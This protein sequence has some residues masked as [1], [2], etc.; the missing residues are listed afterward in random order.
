MSVA[1]SQ[2][3]SGYNTQNDTVAQRITEANIRH[4]RKDSNAGSSILTTNTPRVPHIK[5]LNV[6]S[7]FGGPSTNTEQ[8]IVRDDKLN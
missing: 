8:S 6:I 5:G 3:Q 1:F 2:M 7:Q 4:N